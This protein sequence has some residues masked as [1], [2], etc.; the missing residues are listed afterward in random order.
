MNK[1]HVDKLHYRMVIKENVD[2]DKAPPVTA[3]TDAFKMTA[4]KDGVVFTM[5]EHYATERDARVITDPYLE[6]W[7]LLIGL[8]HGPDEIT[9]KFDH[10]DIIDLEADP[11]ATVI[12]CR[13]A[14]VVVFG[15]QATVHVSHIKFP[16]PPSGFVISPDVQTMYH[17]YMLY[18]EGRDQ[19]PS[20]AY[21]V[22][23]VIEMTRGRDRA[24][25]HYGISKR[26]L[27][28]LG[29][30]CS[31]GDPQD[32]RKAPKDG[33]F[34]PLD[35]RAKAWVESAVKLIIERVGLIDG[36]T[37]GLEPITMADLPRLD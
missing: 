6:N 35:G 3:E 30:F 14:G 24:A 34:V 4:S 29:T 15:V 27:D 36:G 16:D 11:N 18:R 33:A 9:F 32:A 37:V 7:R 10:T 17:R 12:Q 23:T 26:V 28:K 25:H 13:T 19:L 5:K 2:Y 20:M 8:K 21:L 22:L 31:R 1:P